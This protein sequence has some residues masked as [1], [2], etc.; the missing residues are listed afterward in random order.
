[1]A[2]GHSGMRQMGVQDRDWWR[3][4]YNKATSRS[5]AGSA[6]PRARTGRPIQRASTSDRA[7]Q[8]PPLGS[9]ELKVATVVIVIVL[10]IVACLH[11]AHVF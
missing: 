7:P 8:R 6:P 10:V 3:E 5:S 9:F 1:M 4:R 11:K 2:L